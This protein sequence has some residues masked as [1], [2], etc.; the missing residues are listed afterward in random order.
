MH[1]NYKILLVEDSAD[2]E[3]LIRRHFSKCPGNFHIERVETSRDFINALR[4][5]EWDIIISDYTL[6]AFSAQAVLSFLMHSD[7]DLPV[8]VVSGKAGEETAV[9]VM[10]W[11]AKD[12]ICKNNLQRLHPSISREIA[13]HN[14]RK[15]SKEISQ[16]LKFAEAKYQTFFDLN[17]SMIVV[18]SYP[19]E[20]YLEVNSS[21]SKKLGY[22][23]EEL[24]QKTSVE[25]GIMTK[26]D[27]DQIKS[28]PNTLNDE[29]VTNLIC[30]NGRQITCTAINTLTGE[31]NNYLLL[32][33]TDITEQLKKDAEQKRLES[34]FYQDQKLQAIGTLASG[35][36][37]DFNNILSII[38]GNADYI[39]MGNCEN[40]SCKSR[41]DTI[42]QA[43]KRAGDLVKQILTFAR[44]SSGEIMP[45]KLDHIVSDSIK[46][47]K[48]I[49]PASIE[50]KTQISKVP[51]VLGDSNKMMQVITNLCV[52]ASHAVSEIKHDGL[53]MVTLNTFLPD[54]DFLETNPDFERIMYLKLIIDD[55][56][57][58]IPEENLA[59][60]FDPFFTTKEKGRGTG[61]GLS[62]VYGIIKEFNGKIIVDSKLGVG[63]AFNIYLP[64]IINQTESQEVVKSEAKT[65]YPDFKG[66][67]LFVDDEELLV[68]INTSIMEK[69]GLEVHGFTNPLT[70]LD[71]FADNYANIDLIITDLTMPGL[72]GYDFLTKAR[73]YKEIPAIIC[74]GQESKIIELNLET[75]M[76]YFLLKPILINDLIRTLR[77]I[78]GINLIRN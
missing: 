23:M 61:L 14:L 71:Y 26:A 18:M 29:F 3:L 21:F 39:L 22:S 60:I 77:E 1:N 51:Q 41:C 74:S 24:Y 5:G 45:I 36:A 78:D 32:A 2:D 44:E 62:T 73:Q 59:K 54:S 46:M 48:D 42:L 20:R 70:A 31:K 76:N 65:K 58:G 28:N 13:D 6:P 30:K 56:G 72:N 11:G 49:I 33:M 35:I 15:K 57:C 67:V 27:H 12:F 40:S 50:I 25:I 66:R 7:M 55:N 68:E 53:I 37:H 34:K 75:K 8:I 16:K 10:R 64:V 9:E 63:S 17:P 43:G 4:N 69:V 47:L 52:N 38:V 19:E